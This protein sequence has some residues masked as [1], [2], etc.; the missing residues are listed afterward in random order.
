[1]AYDLSG[2]DA[3]SL[4]TDSGQAG[5]TSRAWTKCALVDQY[6]DWKAFLQ[7]LFKHNHLKGIGGPG[8]PHIF[9]FDRR[10]DLARLHQLGR[11]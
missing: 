6:R 7:M 8:A 2:P 10:A 4:S 9:A 3:M 1:M 11:Q 5:P